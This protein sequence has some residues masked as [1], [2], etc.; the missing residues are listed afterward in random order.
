MTYLVDVG[1]GSENYYGWED[2]KGLKRLCEYF[3]SQ[4]ELYEKTEGEEGVDG[5]DYQSDSPYAQ[6][7]TGYNTDTFADECGDIIES[8]WESYKEEC[9]EEDKTPNWD[10]CWDNYIWEDTD[11]QLCHTWLRVTNIHTEDD[12]NIKRFA[13]ES[14]FCTMAERLGLVTS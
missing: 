3:D 13:K 7:I 11:Y 1:S 10:D 8:V 12:E 9:E 4:C 14:D 6:F 5:E 2:Y